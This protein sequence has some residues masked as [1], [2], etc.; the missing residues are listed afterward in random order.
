MTRDYGKFPT[1]KRKNFSM[2]GPTDEELKA[3]PT[4]MLSGAEA[5]IIDD[6]LSSTADKALGPKAGRVSSIA[7]WGESML[8]TGR[9]AREL[10]RADKEGKPRGG[11]PIEAYDDFAKGGIVKKKK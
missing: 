2:G 11:N 6:V 5:G 4:R 3:I 7:C 10:A 1:K 8:P 9:Q